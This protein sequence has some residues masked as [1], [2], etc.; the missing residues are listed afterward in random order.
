[1]NHAALPLRLFAVLIFLL[2]AVPGLSL[3]GEI[4]R[5]YPAERVTDDVYVIHG[6]AGYPSVENQGFMNNP[7]FVITANGVVVIDP[8]SSLQAGRM[9]LAQ[10]RGVTDKPVTHV[11]STHVHGDHWLG[12]HAMVKAFPEAELLAL[13]EMIRLANAS[14]GEFWVRLMENATDGFTAGT[15]AVVPAQAIDAAS[16]MVIGGKTFRFH[17]P[18]QAHST[19]DVMLELVEDSVVFTGD[20]VVFQ[21]FARMDDG[22]FRGNIEACQVAEA[23]GATHY[24]PGH[25]PT[26]GVE[27]VA[28]FR[29]YLETVYGEAGRLY[30]EGL[31]DYEMKPAIVGQ[32]AAYHDWANFED[33]IGK[34]IS[35]A[36]L[37]YERAMFE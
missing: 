31:P 26:G 8:G 29:E 14:Q 17:A 18:G 24:V 22:S 35:L 3:A 7:A 12:N 13:P 23:L 19:T 4:V 10:I 37:E 16:E 6:P 11:F 5:D 9:V 36:V 33:E 15:E 27:I 28:A 34:H 25:G 1:M 30:D 21:R 32:L 20:N 2:A